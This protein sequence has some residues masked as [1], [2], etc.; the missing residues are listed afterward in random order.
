[1]HYA[2]AGEVLEH[3]H[4]LAQ[5]PFLCAHATCIIA[6]S[7]NSPR[8]AAAQVGVQMLLFG[9]GMEFSIAKM[10]EVGAVAILGGF[11]QIVLFVAIAALGALAIGAPLSEGIFVG[12]LV[13]M[14]STSVVI[15]SLG[16][17]ASDKAS[18]IVIG[19]LILQDCSVGLFFAL[20]PVL[21]S[22]NDPTSD[23]PDPDAT[24]AVVLLILSVR[25][26]SHALQLE[27]AVTG[28]WW[29]TRCLLPC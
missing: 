23:A 10:K 21:S 25:R 24:G 14:S 29:H 16:E 28:C 20:M 2:P 6:V 13:S 5:D 8:P 17:R 12:A 7:L 18:Q 3:L 26:R 15:K 11:I 9:L 19:T 27:V 1:M 22:L 4:M